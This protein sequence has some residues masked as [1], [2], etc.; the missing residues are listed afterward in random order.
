[1]RTSYRVLNL[2]QFS[3]KDLSTYEIGNFMTE[4]NTYAKNGPAIN[5]M[6]ALSKTAPDQFAAVMGPDAADFMA[7]AKDSD[8]HVPDVQTFQKEYTPVG[9]LNKMDQGM[10]KS[11][12]AWV[13]DQGKLEAYLQSHPATGPGSPAAAAAPQAGFPGA[14]AAATASSGPSPALVGGAVLFGVGSVLF[15]VVRKIFFKG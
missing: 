14:A 11:L 13:A 7:T 8:S 12:T 9:S 5:A 10:Y 1:M 6:V 3:T 15:V 2:G 4:I